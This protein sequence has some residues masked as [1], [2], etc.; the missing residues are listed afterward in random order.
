MQYFLKK[1]KDCVFY[2]VFVSIGKLV[3]K[4]KKI[5]GDVCNKPKERAMEANLEKD[6][7]ADA[8]LCIIVYPWD[9]YDTSYRNSSSCVCTRGLKETIPVL[10]KDTLVDAQEPGCPVINI[11]AVLPF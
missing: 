3:R 5:D 11:S 1:Q 8:V 6:L 2:R 4:V 10:H 7:L 9:M